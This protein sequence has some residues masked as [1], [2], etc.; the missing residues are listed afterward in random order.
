MNSRTVCYSLITLFFLAFSSCTNSG[1][2][3]QSKLIWID[4]PTNAEI[5][6]KL[7]ET[8][9]TIPAVSTIDLDLPIGKHQLT[10]NGQSVNFVSKYCDQGM[11]LNP[12]LST[13]I[14]YGELFIED[15]VNYEEEWNK[16][17]KDILTDYQLS[18]STIVQLPFQITNDLF[19]EQYK[20]YWQ[21]DINTP[22]PKGVSIQEGTGFSKSIMMKKMFRKDEFVSYLKAEEIELPTDLNLEGNS[23]KTLGELEPFQIVD[24]SITYP[25]D[26]TN[27]MLKS[28]AQQFDS[29]SV[30]PAEDLQY[31]F[32]RLRNN[33]DLNYDNAKKCDETNTPNEEK[34]MKIAI[35]TAKTISNLGAHNAFV[36]K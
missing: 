11:I 4:N 16:L 29:L 31:F 17:A 18:D 12:T 22:F 6:I 3:P 14:Y 28:V 33:P 10:Y 32:M 26:E 19:I 24:L 1:K 15:G 25:C 8:N 36:I 20:Y 21:Y 23:P 30:I 5:S 2:Y 9:Y 27:K 34:F 7:D 35:A 13:Y